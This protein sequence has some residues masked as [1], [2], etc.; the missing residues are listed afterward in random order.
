M[1]AVRALGVV[2]AGE[3]AALPALVGALD[4]EMWQV[5]GVAVLALGQFG[6]GITPP[7]LAA[8]TAKLEDENESVRNA[9]EFAMD[10]LETTE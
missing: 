2:G 3:P 7:A 1:A 9:A 8:V 5:R 10:A 6:A 4:D